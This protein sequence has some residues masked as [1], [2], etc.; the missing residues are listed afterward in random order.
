[1]KKR[2]IF[3]KVFLY[4]TLFIA[5]VISVTAVLFAQQIISFY[6]RT[7]EQF[8]DR[9]FSRLT[10]QLADVESDDYFKIAQEFAEK[11]QSFRFELQDPNG[12]TVFS[13]I[14]IISEEGA[15]RYQNI[16]MSI[17]S[18][19]TLSAS[20]D[21]LDSTEYSQ[22]INRVLLGIVVLL[23]FGILGSIIFARQMTRPIKKLVSDAENMSVLA[24]VPPPEKRNDEIGELSNI[25]HEMYGK[26]KD[27]ISDLEEEKE[28]QR[29]FFAAAS[30]ELKTPLAAVTA[31]LQGMFDNI[32][33]YQDHSKYLWECIKLAREQNK[34]ITEILEIV[35]LTDGKII[36]NPE[37][38]RLRDAVNDAI[39]LC[40]TLIE[41][42]EQTVDVQLSEEQKCVADYGMLNRALSNIIMNAVQNTPASGNIRIWSELCG[43]VVRLCVFNTGARIDENILP[44]LF[45]PFYRIDE[46][47]T[48]S[49]G[50][51][52]LGLTIVAKTLDCMGAPYSL[53]NAPEGILFWME[54]P[55]NTE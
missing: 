39:L 42:K 7:Q 43:D 35:K 28:T 37:S 2:G 34:I 16:I 25:V 22:L 5:L 23:A 13:S 40:Q 50:R 46:S 20:A 6:N 33:E 47:R 53:E 21:T 12:Y 18:G 54:L 26:L 45:R 15:T 48:M 31:L 49:K 51:S 24:P 11:N 30:H 44:K 32:G 10:E 55:V 27:T 29:Y 1:M 9:H 38:I 41:Q 4:T 36:L 52:G 19:Y 17:G 3:L 14:R 8:F